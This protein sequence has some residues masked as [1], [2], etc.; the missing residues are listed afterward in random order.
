MDAFN[1]RAGRLQEAVF[2]DDPCLMAIDVADLKAL[3]DVG[4]HRT[5]KRRYVDARLYR[6]AM[7][8]NAQNEFDPDDEPPADRRTE[9]SLAE[10]SKPFKKPFEGAK[11]P[12]IIAILKR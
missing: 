6:N 4:E 1:K 5:M 8:G 10:G 12:H 7:C 11:K 9:I 3:F 2:L